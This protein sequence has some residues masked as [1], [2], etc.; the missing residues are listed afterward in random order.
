MTKGV[1]LI[2]L[3]SEKESAPLNLLGF[4]FV[5]LG[6]PLIYI[7]MPV[8]SCDPAGCES[9]QLSTTEAHSRKRRKKPRSARPK[10]ICSIVELKAKKTNPRNLKIGNRT[11]IMLRSHCPPRQNDARRVPDP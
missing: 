5:V 1:R 10:T 2:I 9:S 11:L 7:Y 8:H 6:A 3:R 4:P